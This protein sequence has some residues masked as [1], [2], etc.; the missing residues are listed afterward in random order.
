[1]RNQ[2]SHRRQYA[3]ADV[4]KGMDNV[5]FCPIHNAHICMLLRLMFIRLSIIRNARK[6]LVL[7]E[8]GIAESGTHEELLAKKGVYEKLYHTS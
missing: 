1:M 2:Q 5:N 3:E 4:V 6:I 7:P 8:N